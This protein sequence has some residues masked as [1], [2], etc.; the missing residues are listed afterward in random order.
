MTDG[1]GSS[2]CNKC[3]G[4]F[5]TLLN[6][7]NFIEAHKLL[8]SG[9]SGEQY[10]FLLLHVDELPLYSLGS[11]V[12]DTGGIRRSRLTTKWQQSTLHSGRRH[13]RSWPNCNKILFFNC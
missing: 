6:R 11:T 1:G 10:P 5:K 4:I 9:R 7:S 13:T 2:G 12:G 8:K 3:I